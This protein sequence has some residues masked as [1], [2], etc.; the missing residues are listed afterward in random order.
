LGGFALDPPYVAPGRAD[1]ELLA[2]DNV[3]M[4]PHIA[5]QPRHNALSDLADM[6]ERLS[7]AFAERG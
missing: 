4:S 2:F 6:I 5:A 3:V 1:D 7:Q